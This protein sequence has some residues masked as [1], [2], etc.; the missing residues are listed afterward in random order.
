MRNGESDFE[1]LE[2]TNTYESDYIPVQCVVF[3]GS[4]PFLNDSEFFAEI[5]VFARRT[6]EVLSFIVG[7]ADLGSVAVGI[8]ER[9]PHVITAALSLYLR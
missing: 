5:Q 3:C 8:N 7:E 6:P 4:K 1:S 2:F 9:R